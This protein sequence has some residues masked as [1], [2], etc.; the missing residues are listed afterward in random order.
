MVNLTTQ[1]FAGNKTF[2]GTISASNLSGTNTGNVTLG[3]SNGLSLVGQ[4]LS[5][6]L[7]SSTTTGALS[8]VDWNT[9]NNKQAAG[10]YIT[11]LTGDATATGPG[12]VP[13]TLATV[14]GNV[15]TFGTANSVGTFTVNAKGLITAASNT[16]ISLPASQLTGTL[17]AA[18][19]PAL[20]GDVTTTAGSFVTTLATVNANVGTFGSSTSIPTFTVND[21]GL[22]TAASGNVVIAP[23]GTLTGTTLAANVV[24]SSLTSVG[25]ITTGTWNGSIIT[26]P[27]GG[28]GLSTAPANGQLLI[29][30]GTDYTLNTVTAG[31]GISI[32]NAAGSITV[33]NTSPSSGGT[34][35]SVAFAD[36]STNPIYTITGSPI[37][38]SG[39][40]TET[41]KTQT[42]ATFFAGP[43]T[44]AAAQPTFRLIVPTDIPTLNQNTTGTASN[45]TAT[46]NNTLTTLTA[47]ALPTTQLTGTISLTTQVAG[48]LPI[49]NGG[50]ALSTTPTN[51]QLLIGN[52][53][54]YTLNTITPGTGISITNGAGTITVTN[55]LPS[56]GGTVTSVGLSLPSIFTVTGSP[57]TT[58]GT[59]TATFNT[60]P[61]N[62]VFAGPASGGAATPTFRALT[63]A[64]ETIATQAISA[65]NIDWSTGYVFTKTLSAN[66]TFTFSNQLSGQTIV[67][68]VTNTASNWTV[69]WPTVKWPN[70]VAPTQTTGAFSDVYTFIYDGANTYGSFVQN[71]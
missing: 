21:K 49:A 38:T 29:G 69:T 66:T 63:V 57:V 43:A 17:Q 10:N 42:A 46:T 51:G 40:L 28:T 55:T 37:T 4:V 25:T 50:T 52:G 33:T 47:L 15:G 45:I 7:S 54:N 22:I 6:G 3:I 53:T 44:G 30:N 18:Q 8:S 39:T 16:L 56:L 24:N 59:L 31:T 14:N 61:A 19:F 26:V 2:T 11:A 62:T 67:V 70:Q 34:V 13:I 1:S 20:T 32:T 41:L 65:S 12:S 71:F 64:D 48:V 23:A 5:L 9:F 60:E 36:G 35:T 58:S 27:F 68:R